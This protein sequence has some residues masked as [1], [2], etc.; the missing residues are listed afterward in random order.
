MSTASIEL[1]ASTDE[2][3]KKFF[4]LKTVDDIASLFEI[5][6]NHLYYHIYVVPESSRYTTFD[7]K[8]KSGGI[9]T[10]SAPSTALKIIQQK[11]NYILIN[12]YQPK[13]SVHSFL[14]ARSILSNAKVHVGRRNI[15]NIDLIDFFPSINF[16]RVRG[17]FIG[18]PYNRDAKVATILAKICCFNNQL[19]QGA[20]TSPIISNMICAKMDSELIHLAKINR[21]D[22]TRYA[23]DIT[24]STNIRQFPSDIV[25]LDE[26]DQIEVGS[27]LSQ[28]IENN[29]FKV[30]PKKIRLRNRYQHQEVTGI[31]I[32]KFPNLRRRYVRRI[33][34]ML[35]AW[36]KYGLEN[37]EKEFLNRYDKKHRSPWKQTP[38]FKHVVK[39]KIEYL[40]MVRGKDDY[41]YL[42][43]CQKLKELA[44]ELVKEA[45]IATPSTP[46][47]I[48]KPKIYTEGKSDWKHIK[49]AML[50]L[51]ELG[52]YQYVD[53][54]IQEYEGEMGDNELINMCNAH[55]KSA[56]STPHIHIFDRDN[57]KTL[58]KVTSEVKQYKD[59]G[60]NVF[61][62]ALPIPEHRQDT[63]KLSIEHY[64]KD[65]E[66][67]RECEQGRRLYLGK[68]FHSESGRHKTDD[69]ITC[70]DR[71]KT[72]DENAIIDNLVFDKESINVALPKNDFA[73]FVLNRK[74]NFDD[75]DFSG[76]K[77]IFWLISEITRNVT[78]TS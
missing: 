52:E 4:S 16:G 31:T 34:A 46:Q 49:A 43:I 29:G 3:R 6:L 2:L 56:H 44:P 9:R 65:T 69:N 66:L 48:L 8:K 1:L 10:I 50:S 39:G 35:H 37:A 19:P 24:F 67:M 17:L 74:Q 18:K 59:W 73:E 28:I 38:S 25:Q 71:N 30:H 62:F 68:E 64:Y 55:S 51:R 63:P 36:E 22:Y 13:P 33:R 58:K 11:L 21:C 45:M 15:L 14:P 5:D 70:N 26:L 7:I 12:V 76:F 78:S 32:N 42:S 40:G 54:E 57:E 53:L 27:N 23:D 72:R 20:P 60:N 75:F 77:K 47:I 41:L 61:S